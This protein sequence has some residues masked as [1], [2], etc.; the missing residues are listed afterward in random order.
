M[1]PEPTISGR[2]RQAGCCVILPTYNNARTLAGVIDGILEVTEQLIVVNDG[3]TD[4][5]PAILGRYPNLTTITLAR[6]MGKGFAIRTGFRKAVE[7]DYRYAVTI[8]SD[9]QHY[10]G[11]LEKFIERLEEEPGML[12]MG[13]RNMQQDGVPGKSSFGNRFSNFW[14]WVETGLKLPDTQTGFRLYPLEQLGKI[15]Y[16][17]RRFEFEIEVIVRAAWKRVPFRTIPVRVSYPGGDERVTHFRPF[18]DFMRISL[19]NTVLVLLALLFVRPVLIA[20]GINRE[21]IRLFLINQLLDPQETNFRKAASVA[22]G[23]FFGIAPIWGWQM[24]VAFTMAAVLRL[25][26]AIT[27]VASNIS[28]PPMIPLIL[29]ASYKTG[30]LLLSNPSSLRFDQGITFEYVKDN[31]LQYV[32]GS[33]VFGAA[34]GLLLG[35]LTYVIL[36]IFRKKRT[37]SATS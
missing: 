12:F 14:F 29:Y 3:S 25:N 1:M 33:L 4:E 20:Q 18:T 24:V 28:I 26:K 31:L 35:L 8:D 11:D 17:T 27:L 15:K 23:V 21:S 7:L 37:M 32:L 9:G 16:V 10:P 34:M 2:F 5:T 13:T 6:N 19:L 22:L 30:G 36:V